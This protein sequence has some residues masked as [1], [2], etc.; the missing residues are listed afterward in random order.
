M[1]EDS[2]GDLARSLSL[3]LVDIRQTFSYNRVLV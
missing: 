1:K 3:L 2:G